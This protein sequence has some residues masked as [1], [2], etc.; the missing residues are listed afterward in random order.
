[1]TK[2]G[3]WEFKMILWETCQ[4]DFKFDGAWLDIYVFGITIEDWQLLFNVLQPSYEFSHSIDGEPQQFPKRIKDV[5]L[6]RELAK[7][8]IV[9][10][11]RKIFGELPFFL[12]K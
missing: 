12:R 7:S 2:P 9:F 3:I 8:S 6:V 10:S 1:L 11:D 4:Q 5:F